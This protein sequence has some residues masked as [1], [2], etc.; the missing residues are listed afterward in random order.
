[1]HS[2]TFT[3][4]RAAAGD[5]CFLGQANFMPSRNPQVNVPIEIVRT[6]IIVQETG[7]LT[8]AAT[9]LG[10][11]QPAITTQI[12]R[13]EKLLG[14]PIFLK[15]PNG[16][17]ATEL[18]LLVLQQARKMLE[19]NDQMLAIGG[20]AE[21]DRPIR[22]GISTILVRTFLQGS[23]ASWLS[24]VQIHTDRSGNLAHRFLEGHDDIACLLD[25]GGDQFEE[26]KPFVKARFNDRMLWVRSR[27]FTLSPGAP[28]P[29]VTWAGGDWMTRMLVAR[30]LAYRIVFSGED[31][32]AKK[33]AVE[34][35]L[36]LSAL[37]ARLIPETLVWAREDYLPDLPDLTGLLCVRPSADP[38]RV[39]GIVQKL[40]GLFFSP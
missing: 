14:G 16:S 25:I 38:E 7:S 33:A 4:S 9:V 19:A 34:A 37:P 3:C 6:V 18:G 15:T 32:D 39:A 36:G 27:D 1:V 23:A 31:Y 21:G 35:G 24:N 20:F 8:K 22:I 10:L 12:K 28:L 11:S 13:I 2:R 40:S 30:A 26:L 29:I 17:Q 5:A